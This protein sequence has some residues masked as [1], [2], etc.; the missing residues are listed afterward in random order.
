MIRVCDRACRYTSG[1]HGR[2]SF[3]ADRTAAT[4]KSTVRIAKNGTPACKILKWYSISSPCSQLF[5]C[6][7]PFLRSASALQGFGGLN[8]SRIRQAFNLRSVPRSIRENDVDV[9]QS[10]TPTRT[11]RPVRRV[12]E[13]NRA[14][15]RA[16]RSPDS[17]R[18]RFA[19]N[20]LAK[21]CRAA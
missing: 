17:S 19:F 7:N 4:R 16:S 14:H 8:R 1:R 9:A 12:G 18:R 11:C 21:A 5:R 13:V 15:A 10:F 2:S 6:S 20:G 3:V